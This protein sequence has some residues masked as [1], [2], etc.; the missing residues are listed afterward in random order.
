MKAVFIGKG[1]YRI[2]VRSKAKREKISRIPDVQ[3]EGTK[4]VFPEWLSNHI[5]QILKP[6]A[7]RKKPK[8][9]QTELFKI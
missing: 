5:K 7:K 1:M 3:V 6:T 8:A 2:T 9:I 4:V